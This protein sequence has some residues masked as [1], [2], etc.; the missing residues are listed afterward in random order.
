MSD[1]N[2]KSHTRVRVRNMVHPPSLQDQIRRVFFSRPTDPV[3]VNGSFWSVC[4]AGRTQ[5]VSQSG[6]PDLRAPRR[7]ASY[8][9]LAGF[10]FAIIEI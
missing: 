5:F 10:Q 9:P 7:D 6:P 1:S 3:D 4:V 2:L 8:L